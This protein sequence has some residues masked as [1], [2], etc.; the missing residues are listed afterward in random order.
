MTATATGSFGVIQLKG[1]LGDCLAAQIGWAH[2]HPGER[3]SVVVPDEGPY[4][5][6]RHVWEMSS[7][8]AE[9][10]PLQDADV[11]STEAE[12]HTRTRAAHLLRERGCDRLLAL[13]SED[14]GLGDPEEFYA[15]WF[16]DIVLCA[17]SWFHH[18]GA[19][20]A[21]QLRIPDKA[22]RWAIGFLESQGIRDFVV[23]HNR[24]T[25]GGARMREA[26]STHSDPFWNDMR[27]HRLEPMVD[28]ALRVL[29]ATTHVVRVGS[30]G[31]PIGPRA[32]FLDTIPMGLDLCRQLALLDLSRAYL[33]GVSGPITFAWI[34]GK[35][36]LTVNNPLI[37]CFLTREG[38][39]MVG[40]EKH[41]LAHGCTRE[42][43]DVCLL[44]GAGAP[45]RLSAECGY[46]LEENTQAEIEMALLE[47]ERLMATGL[48]QHLV[49]WR[50]AFIT[51]AQLASRYTGFSFE[52][53]QTG[54]PQIF[55]AFERAIYDAQTPLM[56]RVFSR[57]PASSPVRLGLFGASLIGRQVLADFRRLVSWE[58]RFFDNDPDRQGAFVDNVIVEPPAGLSPATTDLVVITV[59]TGRSA[60]PALAQRLQALGW[61]YGE[62]LFYSDDTAPS[63]RQTFRFHPVLCGKVRASAERYLG[64]RL[65]PAAS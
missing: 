34:L 62:N 2:L 11:W 27:N 24:E 17:D 4:A 56:Q 13:P 39:P 16:E 50:G 6:L 65:V 5:Y 29:P 21:I 40:L 15:P 35:P 19:P 25:A 64:E 52:R 30:A 61:V 38:V 55:M 44:D 33:G 20:G 31:E 3:L 9:V 8:S 18:Y 42:P 58:I 51:V 43:T 46:A 41:V 32:R 59:M 37:G 14:F 1:L 57:V 23:V 53:R 54:F 49:L 26:G 28:A 36:M 45:G 48:G 47:L 12:R 60:F 22:R 63:S 10:I 7:L